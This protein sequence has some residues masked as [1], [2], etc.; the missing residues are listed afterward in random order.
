METGQYFSRTG[1]AGGHEQGV[2]AVLQKQYDAC[3][4]WASGQGELS[5]GYSRGNLRAMVDKGMLKMSDLRILW[6]SDPIPNGPTACRSDLPASFKEDMKLFHLALPKVNPE[7]YRQ[8][9]RGA[10]T[11]YRAVTHA[12]FQLI[13]DLRREEATERRRR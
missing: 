1:F 4:T 9:E 12:N 7:V 13:V 10:G 2:I 6:T 3:V 11:G 8:I 5:E